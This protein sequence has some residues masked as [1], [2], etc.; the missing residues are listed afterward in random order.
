MN[1]L[2]LRLWNS[3]QN[4]N[5]AILIVLGWFGQGQ[6]GNHVR[7]CIHLHLPQSQSPKCELCQFRGNNIVLRNVKNMLH[8]LFHVVS[9]G[10]LPFEVW[11]QPRDNTASLAGCWS[12]FAR[13][14][15]GL[16]ASATAEAQGLSRPQIG[17]LVSAYRL[18][19]INHTILRCSI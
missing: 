19:P 6:E 14:L 5:Q 13:P 1:C 9:Q 7:V 2:L 4:F 10:I 18:I 15:S 8:M 12:A 17:H 16:G 3:G 11:G